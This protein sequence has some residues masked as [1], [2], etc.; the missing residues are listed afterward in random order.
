MVLY[1]ALL[2]P[3]FIS[4]VKFDANSTGITAEGSL[5]TKWQKA[6]YRG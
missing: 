6:L 5:G 1:Q 3:T 2:P 4:V